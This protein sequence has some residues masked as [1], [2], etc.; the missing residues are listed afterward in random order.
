MKKT[1]ILILLVIIAHSLKSQDA[2]VEKSIYGVQTGFLGIWLHNESRLTNTI[3]LRSEIGFDS[4]LWGGTYYDY[5]GFVMTPVLT[6]EPR[7]YYNLKN[8]QVKGRRI[9]NNSGN[10]ISLKTSYHPDWFVI[11]NYDYIRIISD[12][13]FIP[14]WGIKRNIGKKFNFETGFGLGYRYIFAKSAGYLED[15]SELAVNLHLRLGYTF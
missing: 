9:S 11:S 1:A 15:E 14:T 5:T 12:I 7:F 4:G 8:R 3:T 13:S 10:F 6:V 2:S